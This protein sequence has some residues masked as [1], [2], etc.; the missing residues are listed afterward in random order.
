MNGALTIAFL[1]FVGLSV[2]TVSSTHGLWFITSQ[3]AIA[4]P[5]SISQAVTVSSFKDNTPD[6]PMCEVIYEVGRITS[7][8][9][10][11]EDVPI[12]LYGWA[13]GVCIH[14]KTSRGIQKVFIHAGSGLGSKGTFTL[15]GKPAKVTGRYEG[16]SWGYDFIDRQM[17]SAL[18]SWQR[19]AMRR[20]DC[21]T[22]L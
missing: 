13:K 16:N 15:N 20:M 7:G 22:C 19:Q 17:L 5:F 6:Q 9:F 2:S 10:D 1:S 3:T 11:G 4:A 8:K 18:V 12:L 14:Y 21:A